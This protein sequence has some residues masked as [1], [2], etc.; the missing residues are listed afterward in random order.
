MYHK[1]SLFVCSVFIFVINY[2]NLLG[3]PAA[4]LDRRRSQSWPP[5]SQSSFESWCSI[6]YWETRKRIGRVF[7]VYSN[8]INVFYELPQG[9]GLCIRL[10]PQGDQTDYVSKVRRHI[11]YGFQL[12][13]EHDGIWIYNRSEYC[14]FIGL[15]AIQS[16]LSI[17]SSLAQPEVTRVPAGHCLKVIDFLQPIEFDR[18][19]RSKQLSKGPCDMYCILVSF[20]KGWGEKYTR[21]FITS[22]PCWAE[23]Y[24]NDS[25]LAMPGR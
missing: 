17:D 10:L 14:I 22:C 15:P 20:A 23:I 4:C 19:H 7:D 16:D 2:H 21:Q 5:S 6:A 12:T 18:H 1:F 8:C 13:K 3:S 9:D 25:C 24:L 11:G